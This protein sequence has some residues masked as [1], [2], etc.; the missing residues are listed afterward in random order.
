[1][2]AGVTAA[3]VRGG[4]GGLLPPFLAGPEAAAWGAREIEGRGTPDPSVGIVFLMEDGNADAQKRWL[5]LLGR[6][7]SAHGIVCVYAP[8]LSVTELAAAY[9]HP[10]RVVGFQFPEGA[11]ETGGLV[12]IA[13]GLQTEPGVLETVE[14]YLKEK[15]YL[16]ERV[17]D[18]SGLVFRR[19]LFM[20]INEAIH[21]LWEGTA[22]RDDIDRAMKLGTNYPMGPLEWGDRIGLDRV[23]EGLR[24]L[25]EE[26]GD[27]RYRPCPLLRKMVAAGRVGTRAGRGFYAYDGPAGEGAR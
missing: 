18:F 1:M 11:L 19:V 12:E 10:G 21:V 14:G 3:V 13:A 2:S 23:Y 24:A 20:V 9:P 25:H 22:S 4:F 7:G 16:T 8:Y 26:Y 17:G 27:E 15:G 6:G 5:S